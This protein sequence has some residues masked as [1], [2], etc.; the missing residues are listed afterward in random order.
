MMRGRAQEAQDHHIVRR[1]TQILTIFF[2]RVMGWSSTVE[3]FGDGE[4][5]EKTKQCWNN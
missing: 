2:F 4:R 5:R 3:K 1:V